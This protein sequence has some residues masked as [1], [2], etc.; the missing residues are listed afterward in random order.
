MTAK[1]LRQKFMRQF[2]GLT[3]YSRAKAWLIVSAYIGQIL[4]SI[5]LGHYL[6]QQDASALTITVMIVLAI[7]IAT[8]Q[9]GL[10]NIVH[11][12]SHATFTKHREDNVLLGSICASFVLGCFK[13]YR[14]EHLTH[15]AHLGDY[16]HDLDLQGIK[17]LRLD[18]P[19]T[20]RVVLRHLTNPLW[21]RHLPY[22]FRVNRTARDGR[23]FQ[24]LKFG[25]ILSALILTI[26][27]PL[28]GFFFVLMPYIMIYST[29]SY[30]TD[31]LDH[32][33]ISMSGDD[34]DSSRNMLAPYLLRLVFFPRN[35]SFH[36]VH[37][38]F[39]QI[40]ASHLPAS[41]RVL[42]SDEGYATKANAV[43]ID[44][45]AQQYH[46]KARSSALT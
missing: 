33:G 34:L 40:P 28:T 18:E 1:Q 44:D 35:D 36:L 3:K 14:D 10:N 16:E 38:L 5:V 25:L 15:H 17:D 4:G 22:Y 42:C 24:V 23:M 41:H 19:L 21:G 43:R 31:C 7:Y 12:C 32:A 45:L 2:M 9:R 39:P 6:L 46:Q 37:H 30:W 8:R 11:E 29:I 13:D 20:P 26:I 27:A